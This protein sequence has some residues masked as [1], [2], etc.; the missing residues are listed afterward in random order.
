M[1][2]FF[3]VCQAAN[4][5]NVYMWR[6]ISQSTYNK[7]KQRRLAECPKMEKRKLCRERIEYNSGMMNKCQ[8][9]LLKSNYSH[10]GPFQFRGAKNT[11][12]PAGDRTL[13]TRPRDDE[14]AKNF[15]IGVSG[16]MSTVVD[17]MIMERQV[18]APTNTSLG[19]RLLL[20]LALGT[21]EM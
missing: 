17:G 19:Y 4:S 12:H 13:F 15:W 9:P 10:I 21:N 7:S 1:E 20:R 8:H 11:R 2:P 5:Q 14:R 3:R 6:A 18:V 16:R